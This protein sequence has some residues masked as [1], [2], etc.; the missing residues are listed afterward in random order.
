MSTAPRIAQLPA[1]FI[2]DLHIAPERP[3]IMAAFVHFCGQPARN[4]AEVFILGDLFEVWI[5]DD[6]DDPAW[7]QA[8]SAL[9]ALTAA[10][11]RVHFLPGN[12]D[13]LVGEAFA[14]RTGIELLP[15]P[16]LLQLGNRRTLL[17]HGDALCTDD[18]DHQA[19]R[20]QVDTPEW[21]Q[22]FLARGL[23]ER[24]EIAS[25]MRAASQ[26]SVSDKA[27]AI[28]DVN[29]DA[30]ARA[31]T[32]SRADTIIHGHT[33]RPGHHEHRVEGRSVERRVLGDWFEQGS[34]L[35]A[36]TDGSLCDVPLTAP[37]GVL[38]GN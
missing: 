9:R 32:A 23:S 28:M 7:Q 34:M 19:F 20:D 33:H 24:R 3:D 18:T 16:A 37:N 5:G 6:D 31:A 26:A 27:D 2:A 4:A 35:L 13:F 30:V 25:G 11:I 36:D 12:R 21:R 38:K 8:E 22:A 10:G 17:T 29:A 14:R 15:D 1:L